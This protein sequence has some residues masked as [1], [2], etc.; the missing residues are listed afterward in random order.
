M[1][2]RA[3]IIEAKRRLPMTALLDRLCTDWKKKNPLRADDNGNSFSVF[4]DNALW[5]DHVTGETGDQITLIE[6]LEGLSR[7]DAIKRFLEEAGVENAPRNG[8]SPSKPKPVISI[9]WP[10][11]VATLGEVAAWRG[12][13]VELVQWLKDQSLVGFYPELV[14]D[15][16]TYK[17]RL[18]FP[19]HDDDGRVVG[20]HHVAIG[21]KDFRTIGNTR[22]LVIG[23]AKAARWIVFESQ[24]DA[25][26]FMQ[27][28]EF[29]KYEASYAV[30]ITRGASNGKFTSIIPTSAEAII[31]MQN[32]EPKKDGTI[33][34]EEW[35][36]K[37]KVDCPARLK[38]ARPPAEV[39]DCNDW[40]K[41]G[42]ADFNQMIAE[43]SA[44]ANDDPYRCVDWL[45][46]NA[47]Q[48]ALP[49][50][51]EIVVGM[52]RR[53]EKA[54]I[55]GSSKSKKTFTGLD[56][57]LSVA[58]GR[59]WMGTETTKV[60]V[61]IVDM[62]LRKKTLQLRVQEIL[63]VRGITLERGQLHIISLRGKV[64]TAEKT[65]AYVKARCPKDVGL[66]FLD[67]F[68]KLAA[69]K[70][71]NKAG[72]ITGIMNVIDDLG[73]EFDASILFSAHYSKG[74]QAGKESIDRISGSGVFGRDADTIISMT[75]HE[76]KDCFTI[77][78]IFRSFA[79]MEPWV[80]RWHY[81]IM[82]RAADLDPADLKK[83][84]GRPES[85]PKEELLDLVSKPISYS[86]WL[87]AAESIGCKKPTFDRKRRELFDAGLIAQT[88]GTRLW[89]KSGGA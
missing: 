36:E 78:P 43:A 29:H 75:A 85:C 68:Y 87:K 22:P 55:G 34:S 72:D 4:A 13:S 71:E 27:E 46:F 20:V 45:D 88:P 24:W 37:V 63:R 69:G 57:V 61:V 79:P 6:K 3:D 84:G 2:D 7:G 35:L 44:I 58:S 60:P 47:E 14:A 8:H 59:P 41:R 26:A 38:V 17:N 65:L 53:G 48:E 49:D 23:D 40:L 83:V 82:E 19:M 56:L 86:D 21:E 30:L 51:V 81:P 77:D 67:P 9:D 62:E 89:V 31:V 16:R 1:S 50:A 5:K 10:A 15:G 18:A 73:R 39:H 32:D 70:D 11:C 80:V 33:P 25:F 12:L 76:E 42:D 52:I 28:L 64:T 66:F 74:N 54:S